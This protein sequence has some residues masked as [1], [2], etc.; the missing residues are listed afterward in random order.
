[1][2]PIPPQ[3]HQEDVQEKDPEEVQGQ[4]F[5][6]GHQLQPRDAYSLLRGHQLRQDQL[7]QGAVEG[8]HEEEKAKEHG[9]DQVRGALQERQEQVVLPEAEVLE[10]SY[11][12]FRLLFTISVRLSGCP[13][14]I[15]DLFQ[16]K[17]KKQKFFAYKYFK[18]TC[19][20]KMPSSFKVEIATIPI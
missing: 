17:K 13:D 2:G 8:P 11:N 19:L 20:L 14:S 5:L 18:D 4:A 3:G 15:P 9:E 10:T 1:M 12:C 7:E 16:K 6:E